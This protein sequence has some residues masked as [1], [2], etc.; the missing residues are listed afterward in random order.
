MKYTDLLE[1]K[2]KDIVNK[3]KINNLP[4]TLIWH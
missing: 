3:E 1:Q 4:P 2:R